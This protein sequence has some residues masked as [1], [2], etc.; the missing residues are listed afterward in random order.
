[1]CVTTPSQQL[2][3]VGAVHINQ[4]LFYMH[5]HFVCMYVCVRALDPLE[6]EL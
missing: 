4:L 6:L 1:M 5:W 3:L 2:F